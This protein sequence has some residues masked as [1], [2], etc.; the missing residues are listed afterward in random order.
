MNFDKM[1]NEEIFKYFESITSD[2]SR[3][4]T[5]CWNQKNGNIFSIE[6]RKQYAE[7]LKN[8]PC[9]TQ[10]ILKKKKSATGLDDLTKILRAQAVQ[11]FYANERELIKEG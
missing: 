8:K 7:F 6:R 5:D 11:D 9:T 3:T 10:S 4:I 2:T 1:T